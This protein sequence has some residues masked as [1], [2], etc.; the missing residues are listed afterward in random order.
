MTT[1]LHVEDDTLLAESVKDAF[2][3]FGFRGTYLVATTVAEARE[4]LAHAPDL[5]LSDMQLPDGSGLDVVRLV[6]SDPARRHVPVVMLSGQIDRSTIDRAYV[7]GANSYVSKFGRG[8]LATTI[9][10][11]YAHWLKDAR[12]PSPPPATRTLRYASR[13]VG[14]RTRLASAYLKI[15]EELP[16]SHAEIWLDLALR[17]GNVANLVE[18]LASQLGDREIPA[19]VLEAGEAKQRGLE[20]QLT[21]LEGEGVHTSDEADRYMRVMIA[22]LHAEAIVRLIAHLFPVVPVAMKALRESGATALDH[23]ADWIEAHSADVELR[24]HV[25]QLH[26]DAARIRA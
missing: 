2:T 5:I 25:A 4:M 12:L 24:N 23:V 9:K 1:I 6:R 14:I 26:D 20:E 10:G 21:M 13:A 8:S 18:F 22:N 19:D 7:L 15:A 17:E 11:L 3:A 16:E